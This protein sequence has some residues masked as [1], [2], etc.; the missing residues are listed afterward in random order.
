MFYR[1]VI[2]FIALIGLYSLIGIGNFKWMHHNLVSPR[3]DFQITGDVTS[4]LVVVEFLNYSCTFCKEL[5][6][7]IKELL[8]LRKDIKYIVRP[9]AFGDEE[10]TR[11]NDLVLAAGLQD[12]FWEMHNAVLEYPEIEV[13]VSFIEETA[14]LFG[15][16]FDQMVQD[17]TDDIVQKIAENN[18][19]ALDQARINSVPSFIVGGDVHL[20]TDENL[21]DLKDLLDMINQSQKD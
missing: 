12:K 21:P 2:I 13:P 4:D 10:M 6:P 18:N 16:D 14:G 17:S 3:A 20:V 7:T 19:N 9:V 1:I 8:E 5:H 15:L 11:T